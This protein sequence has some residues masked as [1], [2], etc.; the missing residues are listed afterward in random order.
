MYEFSNN[1]HK[2]PSPHGALK[3]IWRMENGDM[4]AIFYERKQVVLQSYQQRMRL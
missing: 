2:R 3:S 4:K 1:N